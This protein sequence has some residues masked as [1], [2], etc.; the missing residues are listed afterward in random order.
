ML[1]TIREKEASGWFRRK[2]STLGAMTN[3]P[4]VLE[5]PTRR[6]TGASDAIAASIFRLLYA[7]E[8]VYSRRRAPAS[9]SRST[10]P[11]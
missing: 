7:M 2:R 1:S 6:E 3:S 9:V 8:R 5:A 4:M 10:F 11:S